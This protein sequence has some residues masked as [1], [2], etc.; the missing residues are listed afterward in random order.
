MPERIAP[1]PEQEGLPGLPSSMTAI[2]LIVGLRICRSGVFG[3]REGMM[4]L[5]RK[6]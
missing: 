4:M 2:A 6:V 5:S 3:D 1:L